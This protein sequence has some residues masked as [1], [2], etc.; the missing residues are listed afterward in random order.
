M[1]AHEAAFA[2]LLSTRGVTVNEIATARC[3]SSQKD[4]HAVWHAFCDSVNERVKV[5]HR[6]AGRTVM[7]FMPLGLIANPPPRRKQ[8]RPRH[9]VRVTSEG[10]SSVDTA[11]T[12]ASRDTEAAWNDE[13]CFL[14][15]AVVVFAAMS[16]LPLVVFLLVHWFHPEW[17]LINISRSS[18]VP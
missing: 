7:L 1:P 13:E 3:S 8:T 11:S 18:P 5:I 16:L 17:L 2:T 12:H 6:N 15:K 10:R 4:A 14:L 9:N